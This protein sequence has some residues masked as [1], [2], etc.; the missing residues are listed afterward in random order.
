LVLN[1]NEIGDAGAKFIS[2]GI[3]EALVPLTLI[4]NF[5]GIGDAGAKFLAE[6]IKEARVP[7]TLDLRL[8]GIEDDVQTLLDTAQK[9]N[10]I[11]D[12]RSDSSK[13]LSSLE[14]SL[15]MRVT[16]QALGCPSVLANLVQGCIGDDNDLAWIEVAAIRACD[17]ASY[18]N[19]YSS[20]NYALLAASY[21]TPL[22]GHQ[23]LETAPTLVALGVE[24][25]QMKDDEQEEKRS[26]SRS[27]ALPSLSRP[28]RKKWNNDSA[29][30][31]LDEE[32]Y[33]N[34]SIIEDGG[35]AGS[36]SSSSSSSSSYGSPPGGGGG[37][38]QLDELDSQ[39]ATAM[40]SLLAQAINP[41][42]ATQVNNEA[43]AAF[44]SETLLKKFVT[45]IKDLPEEL[46]QHILSSFSIQQL[47]KF[48]ETTLNPDKF[49]ENQLSSGAMHFEVE[50][51]H[52]ISSFTG[53]S[54][55]Y[56]Q[57]NLKLR[58]ALDEYIGEELIS[59]ILMLKSNSQL[60]ALNFFSDI[61]QVVSM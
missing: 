15:T 38:A 25:E 13:F 59:G 52:A 26:V 21:F 56:A 11:I 8:N 41:V 35:T 61:G 39:Q 24:L 45:W 20:I 47:L 4:L 48:L 17:G 22:G 36:S 43:Q 5:N 60:D 3:K 50:H 58:I 19:K 49:I 37:E 57:S 6:G 30:E 46:Q 29:L 12:A 53:A 51:H 31:L 18:D 40:N 55:A 16:E 14:F 28:R 9:D 33:H 2:E 1:S 27:R 44:E 32:Q 34:V 42:Q 54:Q 7:L 23:A 10:F